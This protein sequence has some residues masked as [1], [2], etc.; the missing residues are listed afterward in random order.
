MQRTDGKI[1]RREE[2]GLALFW[3]LAQSGLCS[4]E[5]LHLKAE[6]STWPVTQLPMLAPRRPRKGGRPRLASRGSITG[7][8]LYETKT[9][10]K[11]TY[12][13]T[14]LSGRRQEP[15]TKIINGRNPCT[16]LGFAWRS[17]LLTGEVVK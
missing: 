14:A 1:R 15:A 5:P 12:S 8:D 11:I 9:N 16:A 2:E 10:R 13:P 4:C 6:V 3:Q 17:M 7:G